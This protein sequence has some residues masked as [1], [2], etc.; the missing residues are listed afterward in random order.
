MPINPSAGTIVDFQKEAADVAIR[1]GRG[2]WPG[3]ISHRLMKL[4]YSPMLSPKLAAGRVNDWPYQGICAAP[5]VERNMLWYCTS[6]S[7]TGCGIWALAALS[8]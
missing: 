4:D 1:W 2:D 7:S 8:R 6:R 5:L 3:L